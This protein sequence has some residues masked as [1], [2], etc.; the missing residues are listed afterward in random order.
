MRAVIAPKAA[1]AWNLHRLTREDPLDVFLMLGSVAAV[2]GPPGQGAYAGANT[3]LVALAAH[4][5]ALG[6]PALTV[7]LGA[8][9]GAGHVA[10]RPGVRDF[11]D[12]IGIRSV[13]PSRAWAA[14]D[15]ALAR[16]DHR[17]ILADIDWS[18][19]R[20]GPAATLT[21][22]TLAP[23]APADAPGAPEAGDIRA[24]LAAAPASGRAAVV[25][26]HIAGIVGRVLQAAPAR[27][28]R[29]RP[30]IELGLDS[31]MAVE[32][33]TAVE[34]EL[35]VAVSLADVLEGLSLAGLADR[36]L[37]QGPAAVPG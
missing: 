10:G 31:L 19:W 6:L 35:G 26:D 22:A 21:E 25:G 17:A 1:A 36:V 16:G 13:P 2:I 5:R 28:D 29:G 14:V 37:A 32:V 20:R 9:S 12:R 15:E 18:A 33:T 4:R 7:E 23:L 3:F 8:V 11:L 27:L 34:R 24:R 30:L